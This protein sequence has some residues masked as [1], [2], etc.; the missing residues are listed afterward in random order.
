MVIIAAWADGKITAKNNIADCA[1]LAR[2]ACKEANILLQEI[3]VVIY[4]GVYRPNFRSEPSCAAH[5]QSKLGIRCHDLELS[6]E[7]CFSFDIIDGSRGAHRSIQTVSHFIKNLEVKNA[8]IV[9]AD[10][11]PSKHS[12]W[13]YQNHALAMVL[14]SNDTG[15]EFVSSEYNV[16]KLS[17]YTKSSFD[18]NKKATIINYFGD[19]TNQGEIKTETEFTSDSSSLGSVQMRDFLLWSQNK[20]GNLKH[21]IVDRAGST[22]ATNWS[23]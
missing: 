4:S 11:K 12:K 16:E 15:L 2:K 9:C 23:A 20:K 8:L 21:T 22:S 3:D 13:P 18:S 19:Y 14:S 10:V 17:A 7:H 1:K 5:I 6:S